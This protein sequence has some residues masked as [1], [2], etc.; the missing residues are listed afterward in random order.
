MSS[1]IKKNVYESML[2]YKHLTKNFRRNW[3]NSMIDWGE[4]YVLVTNIYLVDDHG[5]SKIWAKLQLLTSLWWWRGSWQSFWYHDCEGLHC[6]QMWNWLSSGYWVDLCF[7]KFETKLDK[8]IVPCDF[9]HNNRKPKLMRVFGFPLPMFWKQIWLDKPLK[10]PDFQN[11]EPPI[12]E[13]HYKVS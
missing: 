12:K 8:K 3:Y 5:I 2:W 11:T 13:K 4:G 9:D 1:Q 10:A 6:F 7:A